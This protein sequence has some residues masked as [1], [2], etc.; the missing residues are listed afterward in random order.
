M[1]GE[2]FLFGLS[3]RNNVKFIKIKIAQKIGIFVAIDL[4]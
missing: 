4:L 2:T 1:E 3:R